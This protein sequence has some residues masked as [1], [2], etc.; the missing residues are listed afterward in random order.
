[1]I[2]SDIQ[3][4]PASTVRRTVY[5][6]FGNSRRLFFPAV[7]LLTVLTGSLPAKPIVIID[8]VPIDEKIIDRKLKPYAGTLTREE[9]MRKR[10]EYVSETIRLFLKRKYAEQELTS[11]KV[12]GEEIDASIEEIKKEMLKDPDLKGISFEEVLAFQDISIA[13]LRKRQKNNIRYV[14]HLRSLVTEEKCREVFKKQRDFFDGTQVSVSMI[15]LKAS[16]ARNNGPDDNLQ[17]MRMIESKLKK[18]P[19]EAAF[20]RMARAYS[21]HPSR[22]KGGDIGYIRRFGTVS[23]S[24]ARKAFSMKISEISSIVRGPYGYYI[25]MVTDRKKGGDTT[26]AECRASVFNY[27]LHVEEE[28]LI[29]KLID[30]ANI[31]FLKK[32]PSE[33]QK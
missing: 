1:M 26:Y 16:G 6:V 2:I 22:D 24:I 5:T 27:L 4:I 29:D 20:R 8:G 9:Y 15:F 13:E 18:D 32:A 10:S 25:I 28:K 12:T 17:T 11:I 23:D 7:L 31:I 33:E 3:T 19:S 21:E 14:K 30:R